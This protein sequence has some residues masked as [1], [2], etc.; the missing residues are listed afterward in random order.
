[1]IVARVVFPSPGGPYSSTWSSASPR[2]RA[3][4]I[5]TAKFSLT[6]GCPINS[7]SRCGRSFSSNDESSSTGAA[8]TTRCFRSG[9]FLRVATAAMVRRKRESGNCGFR[10]PTDHVETAQYGC[11]SSENRS[12]F[13]A[14]SVARQHHLRNRHELIPIRLVACDQAISSDHSLRPVCAEPQMSAIMQE[15]DVSTANLLSHL[16][17]DLL[18]RRRVPVVASNVPHHRLKPQLSRHAEHFGPPS[19]KGRTPKGRLHT[20]RI[21]QRTLAVHQ[22]RLDLSRGLKDQQRM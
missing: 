8:D 5:A 21:T 16:L 22:F 19:S 13:T 9:T 15:N 12:L 2:E 3:A 10:L 11:P 14:M 4:S 6:L 17:F 20:H 1:M 7:A 18:R